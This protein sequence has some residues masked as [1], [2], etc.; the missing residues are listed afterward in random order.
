VKI[1]DAQTAETLPIDEVGELCTRGYAV[2]QGYFNDAESTAG[3][4]DA[5]GW[6]HTGDL[7]SMDEHGYC[8]IRGRLRDLIIRGGE[9]IYP[10]E[11]ED[12]LIAHPDIAEA[13]VVGIPDD[14]W[15]EVVGAFIRPFAGVQP[16]VEALERYCR[17]HLVSYK[18]PRH[19][20]FVDAFPQTPSGKI[21]K[22]VLRAQFL[23]ERNAK[24][25]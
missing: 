14:K 9:N 23:A 20:R 25:S 2:M 18:T 21:Q 12:L 15:G 8:S 7:A 3:V 1:A 13:A 10:R 17:E 6:L 11:I 4:I 22:F 5:D 16:D 19:W 24:G